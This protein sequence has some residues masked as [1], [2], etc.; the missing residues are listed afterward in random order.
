MGRVCFDY[1]KIFKIYFRLNA[2]TGNLARL[3]YLSALLKC[4]LLA[5]CEQEWVINR[6]FRICETKDLESFNCQRLRLNS[7]VKKNFSLI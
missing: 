3:K 7:I 4:S 6:I 2:R 5:M 1:N